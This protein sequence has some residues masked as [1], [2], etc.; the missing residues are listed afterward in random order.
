M[1]ATDATGTGVGSTSKTLL[2]EDEHAA[3]LITKPVTARIKARIDMR[4]PW[5]VIRRLDWLGVLNTL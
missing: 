4:P 3:T 2:S 1:T 5:S